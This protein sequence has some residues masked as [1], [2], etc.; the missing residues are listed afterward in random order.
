[1]NPYKAISLRNKWEQIDTNNNMH[2]F[3]VHY[4]KA[5]KPVFKGFVFHDSIYMTS[6]RRQNYR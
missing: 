6:W 1:M 4:N 5:K 2:I 3:Q